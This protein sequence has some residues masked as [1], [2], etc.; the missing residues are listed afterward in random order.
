METGRS[1]AARGG[2]R[3][4]GQRPRRRRPLPPRRRRGR[5]R[6]QE[7]SR[8]RGGTRAG[9]CCPHPPRSLLPGQP[10]PGPVQC[11][12]LARQAR[13]NGPAGTPCRAIHTVVGSGPTLVD[14]LDLMTILRLIV[15]VLVYDGWSPLETRPAQ[16]LTLDTVSLAVLSAFVGC[17]LVTDSF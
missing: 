13:R 14:Q 10:A 1:S 9:P 5:W 6:C 12:V 17:F 8:V 2:R 15:Y 3:A 4:P 7:R 11:A 16:P